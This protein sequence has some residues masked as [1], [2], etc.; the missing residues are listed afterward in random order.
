MSLESLFE[1]GSRTR[2]PP[3]RPHRAPGIPLPV[4]TGGHSCSLPTGLQLLVPGGLLCPAKAEN[5]HNSTFPSDTPQGPGT[6]PGAVPVTSNREIPLSRSQGPSNPAAAAP[7]RR[8]R[9]APQVSGAAR[10][11]RRP[12]ACPGRL[13]R[14]PGRGAGRGRRLTFLSQIWS[15]LLPML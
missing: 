7:A 11:F 6:G 5:A 8:G 3:P 13:R 15:G 10:G 4:A 1:G 9:A 14:S 2:R 12:R